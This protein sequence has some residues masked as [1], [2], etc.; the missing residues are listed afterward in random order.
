[1]YEARSARAFGQDESAGLGES[2]EQCKWSVES[3]RENLQWDWGGRAAWWK[4]S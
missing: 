1:M 3:S 4:V 2:G